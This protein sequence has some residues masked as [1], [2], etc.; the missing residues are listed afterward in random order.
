M[1]THDELRAEPRE[2]L[3]KKVR[4]LR[5]AGI[6]PAT[7]YGHAVKPQSIQMDAHE[8]GG[9]LRSA[10]R[11]QLIDLVIGSER[12]RPVF[13][14][15]TTIDAKRHLIQHVE[16][17]QANLL[18]R[19]HSQIPI[20]YVGD[21][22]AVKEG[23][24]FLAVLDHIEVESLPDDVPAHGF[25]V[26]ISGLVDFNDQLHVADL[27]IPDGV[28]LLTPEDE[29]IAKVNPPVSEEVVE[30]AVAATES[31]PTELGGDQ[32]AADAVSDS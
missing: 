6:L 29:V 14:K 28:T 7:V 3:G 22:P 23:G 25:K 8:F 24:I 17:Y 15:Q 26:D 11:N 4:R 21:S 9:V 10:G 16:F 12:A 31:L 1:A 20:H 13:I 27:E 2:M 18:E 30:E 32:T 5:R 19:M